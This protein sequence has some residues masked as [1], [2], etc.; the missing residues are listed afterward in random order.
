MF[1]RLF[2][3]QTFDLRSFFAILFFSCCL[4]FPLFSNESETEFIKKLEI[5]TPAWVR[6]Q[7][8]ADLSPFKEKPFS[9]QKIIDFYYSNAPYPVLMKVTIQDNQLFIETKESATDNIRIRSFTNALQ[10]VCNMGPLPNVVFLISLEDGLFWDYSQGEIPIFAQSKE[11]GMCGILLPDF[12]ALKEGYQVLKKKNLNSY[13]PAWKKKRSQLIWRGSTAQQG[14]RI[15]MTEENLPYF[16][17]VTLCKLSHQYP[18]LIDARFTIFAQGGESIPSLQRYKGEW[19]SYN[20]QM[21]YKYHLLID[22][23]VSS[24]TCSGWRFFSNSVV[25]IPESPWI[26]WYYQA[27]TPYV[28]YIPVA[29]DLSDLIVKIEWAIDH[30]K[31]AKKI[32]EQ[33]RDFALNHLTLPHCLNYIY[34]A[35]WKYSMLPFSNSSEDS[36]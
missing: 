29:A 25:F 24:Y 7:V 11:K 3:N 27:L 28:D 22:G 19:V 31:E 36:L 30:D 6:S 23:N 10:K 2:S 15:T 14:W 12:E 17:R 8:E 16:S 4:I 9:I 18:S 21:K 1:K 13:T 20:D 34:Y 35:I 32:A 33:A 26:Q 5:R